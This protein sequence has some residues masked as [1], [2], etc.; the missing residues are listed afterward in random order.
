MQSTSIRNLPNV[1]TLARLVLV[2]VFIWMFI[3]SQDSTSYRWASAVIFLA[4]ALT[5][6]VDGHIARS[7]NLVTNF[8]KIADPI[9]DKLLTGAALIALS[10]EGTVWWW[11]TIII[12]VR[13]VGITILR[14]WVIK[15][16]VIDASRGGK[17]K[18]ASQITA[19]T[20]LLIPTNAFTHG[21]GVAAMVVAFVLTVATGADY[22]K[23]VTALRK[24]TKP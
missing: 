20:A 18:T 6:L 21:V 14:L 5:D 15:R 3:A 22:L 1:L 12:M 10:I 4:A 7:R 2:P 17:A 24:T 23:Q 8:G 9:A 16:A 13:E 19:I 11:V